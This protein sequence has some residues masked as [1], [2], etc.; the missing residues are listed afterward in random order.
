MMESCTLESS[1]MAF[2]IAPGSPIATVKMC[3]RDR[4]PLMP[5]RMVMD[6]DTKGLLYYQYTTST[7][8]A[9]TMKG[10][11]VNLPPSDVL[12]I[13]GLGFDGLVGY[14]SLIHI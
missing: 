1:S 2:C 8:D 12:H 10:V 4:Y 5:N 9:P 6:R 13:P 11:T 7:G 3:I 14:L